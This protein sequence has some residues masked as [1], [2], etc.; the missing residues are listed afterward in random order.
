[1]SKLIVP[2]YLHVKGPFSVN[3]I[4]SLCNYIY[5]TYI[6][7]VILARSLMTTAP[8]E[9]RKAQHCPGAVPGCKMDLV[10]KKR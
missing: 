6:F 5:N 10:K 8:V 9:P 2:I 4:I 1:M 7:T 3:H